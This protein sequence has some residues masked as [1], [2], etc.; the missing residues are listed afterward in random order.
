MCSFPESRSTWHLTTAI[1][2]VPRKKKYEISGAI[3]GQQD[4]WVS[5]VATAFLCDLEQVVS[6]IWA[7]F[8]QALRGG[9]QGLFKHSVYTGLHWLSSSK[10]PSTGLLCYWQRWWKMKKQSVASLNIFV[11]LTLN[12]EWDWERVGASIFN[13]QAENSPR[14]QTCLHLFS[15]ADYEPTPSTFSSLKWE[16]NLTIILIR[17]MR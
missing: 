3:W 2:E 6:H 1:F 14:P 9:L 10:G 17:L 5:M 8:P 11:I 4:Q 16:N 12:E 15:S 7:S 13:V